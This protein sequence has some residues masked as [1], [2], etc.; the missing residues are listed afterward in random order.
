MVSYTYD[1]ADRLVQVT[2]GTATVLLDYDDANRRTALTLPNGIV[3]RYTYDD[4]NRLTGILYE[5]APQNLGNLSYE[6]DKN[7]RRTSIDGTLARV[8]FPQAIQTAAYDAANRLLQWGTFELSYDASGNLAS[9]GLTSYTW[10]ARNEL[11]QI[12]NG[13]PSRF[14]YDAIGRRTG[15][16][17]SGQQVQFNYDRDTVIRE[18]SAGSTSATL[19]GGGIRTWDRSGAVRRMANLCL[20]RTRDPELVARLKVLR[21]IE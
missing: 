16:S 14:T 9:D 7:G 10:N 3:T 8:M 12:D 2:R 5:R 11:T 20:S 18:L 1:L 21:A 4:A 13:S 17:D 6:Y 19:S 15:K